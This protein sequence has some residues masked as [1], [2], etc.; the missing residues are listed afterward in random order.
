[1]VIFNSLFVCLPEVFQHVLLLSQLR[2]AGRSENSTRRS[3]W[4][5]AAWKQM[6]VLQLLIKTIVHTST[7]AVNGSTAIVYDIYIYT[8]TYIY[9]L[10]MYIYI[11]VCVCA[12]IYLFYIYIYIYLFIYFWIDIYI[13]I[14]IHLFIYLIIIL[15][16]IWNICMF[17]KPCSAFKTSKLAINWIE[18]WPHDQCNGPIGSHD[19]WIRGVKIENWTWLTY[20]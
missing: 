15:R 12:C 5:W 13:Y 18:C 11:Y 7:F 1:M 6:R 9:I 17:L 16:F 3:R 19:F 20:K 8:Y 2:S 10:Y 4:C 14:F